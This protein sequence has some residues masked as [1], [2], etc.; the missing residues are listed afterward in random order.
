M[1]VKRKN[2]Q[3]DHYHGNFCCSY[4]Y[5]QV[6]LCVCKTNFNF[7]TILKR[8]KLH[9]TGRTSNFNLHDDTSLIYITKKPS[10]I[11]YYYVPET[12]T[13]TV[14]SV[15][16]SLKFLLVQFRHV[17]YLF[18][19]LLRIYWLNICIHSLS[20]D[21]VVFLN[22]RF[23]NIFVGVLFNYLINFVSKFG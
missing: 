7:W 18:P 16:L 5:S 10:T 19:C 11:I 21:S 6:W 1:Y 8:R 23:A 4:Y 12:L 22:E 17:R 3:N 14:I 2:V 13:K 20:T 15:T 9:I